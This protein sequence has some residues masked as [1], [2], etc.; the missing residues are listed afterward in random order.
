MNRLF[1]SIVWIVVT[2]LFFI[3]ALFVSSFFTQYYV[4][5]DYAYL[6]PTEVTINSPIDATVT[7]V[8]VRVGQKISL[9]DKLISFDSIDTNLEIKDKKN[10][11][12]LLDSMLKKLQSSSIAESSRID[13]IKM[14][15]DS[16]KN[17]ILTLQHQLM[18]YEV[19]SPINGD[20][21]SVDIYKN[22]RVSRSQPL[23][24]LR[25]N[26]VDEID[27]Y[28]SM[29]HINGLSLG[30]H[31][32]VYVKGQEHEPLDAVITY[33][34]LQSMSVNSG[35]YSSNVKGLAHPIAN[36]Y[37]VTLRVLPSSTERLH[38]LSPG[39]PVDVKMQ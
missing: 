13:K 4:S 17:N 28:F 1:Y 7:S 23:L 14:K 32:L 8:G 10:K 16:I 39:V 33:I 31:A 35:I 25:D 12:L 37:L 19:S 5:S 9:G 36:E 20:V 24:I 34:E 11:L 15:I 21:L 18:F 2:L 29:D 27:A 30:Q 3:L 22:D 38:E 6:R 26:N